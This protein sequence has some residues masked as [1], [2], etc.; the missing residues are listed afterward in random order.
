MVASICVPATR[1]VRLRSTD[2]CKLG[3]VGR[4]SGDAGLD[5][6]GEDV[7][8]SKGL[9]ANQLRV[10]PDIGLQESISI[11]KPGTR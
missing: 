8:G 4:D 1:S 6:K 7:P 5:A 9:M 3:R 11:D 2:R 10:A